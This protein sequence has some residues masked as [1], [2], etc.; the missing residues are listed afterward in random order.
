MSKR[1]RDSSS[2]R[3]LFSF[4]L[5]LVLVVFVVIVFGFV[6]FVVIV[7]G[8]VVFVVI[9]FLTFEVKNFKNL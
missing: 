6:V 2:A 5:T 8:F 7:F 1:W 4:Y 3:L 9:V